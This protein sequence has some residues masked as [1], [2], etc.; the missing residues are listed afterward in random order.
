MPAGVF[1]QVTSLEK[2]KLSQKL[3]FPYFPVKRVCV[4]VRVRICVCVC[5]RSKNLSTNKAEE[6]ITCQSFDHLLL[7]Q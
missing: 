1:A 5:K 4:C 6:G 3:L 2:T 7:F